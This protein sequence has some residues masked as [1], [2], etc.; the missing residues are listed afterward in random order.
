MTTI[1]EELTGRP[2]PTLAEHLIRGYYDIE[3]ACILKIGRCPLPPVES[4]EATDIA[5]FISTFFSGK[6]E[7]EDYLPI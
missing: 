7:T 5:V 4:L 6:Y 3:K 1:P 2:R